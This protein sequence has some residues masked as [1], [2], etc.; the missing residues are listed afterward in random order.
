MRRQGLRRAVSAAALELLASAFLLIAFATSAL[1]QSPAPYGVNDAG[2][3]RN[4]LPAGEAGVDSAVDLAKF[5]TAGTIPP[6]FDDQLPLYTGLLYAD[7]TLTDAQVDN[8][9]KD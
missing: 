8:Y 3:F 7:P 9:F 6:H 1:G 4:V 2:G 5:E